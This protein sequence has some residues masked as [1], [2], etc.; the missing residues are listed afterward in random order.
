MGNEGIL[1]P[2]HRVDHGILDRRPLR[3][4]APV[5]ACRQSVRNTATLLAFQTLPRQL[6][7][8]GALDVFFALRKPVKDALV[9]RGHSRTAV[10]EQLDSALLLFDGVDEGHS[11]HAGASGYPAVL[12]WRKL[13][14]P[15]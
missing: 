10:D 5:T 2:D 7:P 8:E 13:G 6:A 4:G 9:L 12:D 3:L 14:M 11:A 15:R 1:Q